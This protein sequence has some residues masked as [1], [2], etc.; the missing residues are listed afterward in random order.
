MM[1]MAAT[2]MPLDPAPMLAQDRENISNGRSRRLEALRMEPDM[3]MNP[4]KSEMQSMI[5]V[6]MLIA[7]NT[8]IECNKNDKIF[9]IT[10]RSSAWCTDSA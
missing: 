2:A 1:L 7:T 5:V 4:V 3:G 8:M 9:Q 10:M 6:Y